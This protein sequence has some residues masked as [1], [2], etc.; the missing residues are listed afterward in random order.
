[1]WKRA[2]VIAIGCCDSEYR[3]EERPRT[4]TLGEFEMSKHLVT[5]SEY[6][7]FLNSTLGGSVPC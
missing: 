4:V 7:L 6:A 2:L 5:V 3:T 1:M